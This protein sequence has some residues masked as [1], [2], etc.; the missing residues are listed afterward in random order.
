[1]KPCHAAALAVV[2]WYL[3]TPPWVAQGTFDATAPVS[4]WHQASAYDSAAEC[5]SY[6][7][8]MLD[9]YKAHPKAKDADWFE[10]VFGASQCIAT[11][12][13]RLKSD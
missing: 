10:R 9:Y 2:G 13:P 6:R 7:S 4:K 11:D 1:M 3:M 12:D 5:Q 8:S